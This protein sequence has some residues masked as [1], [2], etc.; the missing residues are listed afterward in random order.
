VNIL[1]AQLEQIIAK[2]LR[3]DELRKAELHTAE[4]FSI[5]FH[6]NHDCSKKRKPKDRLVC[7]ELEKKLDDVTVDD[8]VNFTNE[9]IQF[10]TKTN[11]PLLVGVVNR[12]D[13]LHTRHRLNKEISA[14]AYAFKIFLNLVDRHMASKNEKA[15]LIADDFINQIPRNIASLPLYVRIKDE[16][17]K[18]S[19]GARKE[20]VLLRVLH[21]SM[22][23]KYHIP[24]DHENIAPLK[25]EFESKNLFIVDNINYT[26]SKD[27][28]LNQ[29]ADFMIFILRKV[30][31]IHNSKEVDNENFKKLADGTEP[32]L[33]FAMSSSDIRL[34]HIYNNDIEFIGNKNTIF[35]TF[36][37]ICKVFG[38]ESIGR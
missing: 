19:H 32:S 17:L 36:E 8:F 6:P 11:T 1:E 3:L 24:I 25:Y 21:E 10:L 30:I 12:N 23:W 16:H 31:E 15:L 13:T 4:V 5:L 14:I 26:N 9:L 34:A 29:V 20:L 18:T 37:K 35:S 2:F 38:K 33:R 28:I 27:S 7:K 22:N